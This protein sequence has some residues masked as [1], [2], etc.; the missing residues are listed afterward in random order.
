MPELD[1]F[2][3]RA[4]ANGAAPYKPAEERIPKPA[5]LA[6]PSESRLGSAFKFEPYEAPPEPADVA[7][8]GNDLFAGLSS[9]DAVLRH[10]PSL[11]GTETS[12]AASSGSS[13]ATAAGTSS[14][15]KL[16]AEKPTTS[17]QVRYSYVQ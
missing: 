12:D 1:A 13:V 10:L 3:R 15:G 7:G 6:A 11:R 5:P 17:L 2:V 8:R 14:K 9:N 4:L 16:V